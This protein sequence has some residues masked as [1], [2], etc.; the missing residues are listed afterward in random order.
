MFD[1]AG[2]GSIRLGQ[3]GLLDFGGPFCKFAKSEIVNVKIIN[4]T[5][6]LLS[7]DNTQQMFFGAPGVVKFDFGCQKL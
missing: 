6:E 5:V 7:N 2:L 3:R 1:L 4:E